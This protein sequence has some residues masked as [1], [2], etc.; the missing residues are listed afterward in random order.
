MSEALDVSSA[1]ARVAPGLLKA[2]A[3]VSD[4]TVRR[5]GVDRENLKPYRKSEKRSHFSR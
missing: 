4:T 5:S 1:T 3:V 2:L